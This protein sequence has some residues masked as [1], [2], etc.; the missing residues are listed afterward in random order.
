LILPDAN[1]LIYAY[2]SDSPHHAAAAA[3]WANCL[4]GSESVGLA[5]VVVS[6]FVRLL[7]N[8]RVVISPPPL[9]EI[10]AVIHTWQQRSNVRFLTIGGVEHTRRVLALLDACG[11]AG[12][13]VGDAELAAVALEHDAVVYSADA[14]FARF[15]DIR[16]RNPLPKR[17]LRL[18]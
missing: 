15:P 3:W 5:P 1:L 11:T 14:D 2:N 4:G 16:W 10:A 8:P 9:H 18:Q 12:N 13:L 7:T 6:A 17:S